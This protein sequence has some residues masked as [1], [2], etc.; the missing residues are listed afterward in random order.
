MATNNSNHS[1][2]RLEDREAMIN[3]RRSVVPMSVYHLRHAAPAEYADYEQSL[4]QNASRPNIKLET[5]YPVVNPA[6]QEHQSM[7]EA[8]RE[9]AEEAYGSQENS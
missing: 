4:H 8:A 1:F 2:E 5:I 3:F 9:A 6:D 7:L